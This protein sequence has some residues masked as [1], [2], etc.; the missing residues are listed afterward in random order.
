MSVALVAASCAGDSEIVAPWA[1]QFGS[2]RADTSFGVAA[3]PD[4]DVVV[5]LATEGSFGQ[6]NA[7][8]R[9][10][11]LARYTNEGSAVWQTQVGGESNDSPLGLS[12]SPDGFI[13]VGGFTEGSFAGENAGSAD[14]WLSIINI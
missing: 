5:A 1:V 12:V 7:G 6:P 4:G 14:V 11:V 13:Y 2:P 9:D 10:V 3:A 8:G